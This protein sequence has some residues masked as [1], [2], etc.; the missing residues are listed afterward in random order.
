MLLSNWIIELFVAMIFTYTAKDTEGKTKTGFVEAT[1][2]DQVAGILRGRQLVPTEIKEK[3]VSSLSLFLKRLRGISE[4]E[5]TIFT[6]QLA[7]M[8]AAGLPL[9]R[10][11]EVL[12]AQTRNPRFSEVLSGCLRDVQ[13]GSP[14]S[15][16][17]EKHE[18]VFSRIYISLIRAGEASGAL[19][20]ILLRLA[21]NQEKQREFVGKTKGALIYPAIVVVGMVAVF[22]MM[23]TFVVPKLM[24]MYR[25]LGASLPLPTRI[26]MGISDLFTHFWWALLLLGVLGVL[27]ILRFKK[28]TYGRYF[29][30]RLVLRLP[31]VG[32]ISSQSQLSELTRTLGLL[33]GNG[34]PILTALDIGKGALGN[35]LYLEAIERVAVAVEKGAP[36]SSALKSDPLFPPSMGQMVEVGEETGKVDEVLFKISHFF[37][38]EVDQSV[39]NLSTALEPLIM[40]LLG[41]MVGFLILSVILPIYSL[42]SQL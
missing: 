39:K 1:S 7:T 35:V 40:V 33:I 14:L 15:S 12:V 29:L 28:T 26:L 4:E 37:E 16:S 9:A 42:T 32:P 21:D 18:D 6:R 23:M 5:K 36:L 25:D 24:D 22:V 30:A 27:G 11:L 20:K 3:E 13:T 41:V 2:T 19:D 38:S 17:L 31:I 10:A 8:V 34:I